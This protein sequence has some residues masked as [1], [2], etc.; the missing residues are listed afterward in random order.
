MKIVYILKRDLD[1]TGKKIFEKHKA[2]HEVTAVTV[3][4]KSAD[5]LLDLIE[6]NDRV[7]MW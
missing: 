3:N 7:I 1:E 4:E 2:S 6:S 5:E